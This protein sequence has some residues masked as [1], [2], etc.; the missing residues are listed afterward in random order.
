MNIASLNPEF[1]FC[2]HMKQVCSSFLAELMKPV[3]F[4]LGANYVTLN[5]HL[6]LKRG[7]SL[8]STCSHLAPNLVSKSTGNHHSW[9][10]N[11]QSFPEKHF[12]GTQ[13]Q[14]KGGFAPPSI[15]HPYSSLVW[16]LSQNAGNG[17]FGD[18]SFQNFLESLHLGTRWTPPPPLE[19]PGYEISHAQHFFNLGIAVTWI[20]RKFPKLKSA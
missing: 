17:H 7:H 12:P 11:F 5:G 6:S 18:S 16:N 19:T 4:L 15:P 1:V 3:P 8:D 13:W 14:I 2:D 9:E 20:S 10:L